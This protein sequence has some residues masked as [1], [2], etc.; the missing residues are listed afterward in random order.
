MKV[1]C[2]K[3]ACFW[4]VSV[5]VVEPHSRSTVPLA[6]S[7]MRVCDTTGMRRTLRSG[8]FSSAFT[9]STTFSHRSIE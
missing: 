6:T 9:A 1:R 5:L 4:R 2:E 3:S 8:I 7:G